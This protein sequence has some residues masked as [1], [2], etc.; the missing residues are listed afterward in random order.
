M[1]EMI[2]LLG[3]AG[4][5]GAFG[6]RVSGDLPVLRYEDFVSLRPRHSAVSWRGIAAKLIKD[7]L[8]IKTLRDGKTAFQLT[9][10]GIET[11]LSF[12]LIGTSS[13]GSQ[14][15]QLC[16]LKSL[17]GKSSSWVEARRALKRHGFAPLQ[18]QVFLKFHSSYDGSLAQELIRLGFLTTF[19][20]VKPDQAQPAG[21]QEFVEGVGEGFIAL[22]RKLA[23]TS[24]ES[25]A[26]LAEV[27]KKKYVHSKDK[28]RIG[29]IL[30]SGLHL[31]SALD[32]G[33]Y[34]KKDRYELSL[35]LA[36]DLRELAEYTFLH[37]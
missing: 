18:G 20:P 17:P 7:R 24:R 2:L 10:S 28:Q 13:E 26:L 4:I 33:W 31:I 14:S 37:S 35:S 21:L 8:V 1:R 23:E 30:L 19:I 36:K 22:Q 32:P 5:E 9:R 3:V 29:N 25:N 6:A 11:F 16:L 34:L 27:Q 15:W 12:F